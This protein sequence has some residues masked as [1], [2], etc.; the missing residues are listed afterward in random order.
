MPNVTIKHLNWVSYFLT[1][2]LCYTFYIVMLSVAVA[3]NCELVIY[4]SKKFNSTQHK[5]EH[6]EVFKLIMDI[7]SQKTF[8]TLIKAF[9]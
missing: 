2:M 9:L 5:V 3:S 6:K 1:I 4:F 8:S 7:H